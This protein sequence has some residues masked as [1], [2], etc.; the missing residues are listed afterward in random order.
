MRPATWSLEDSKFNMKPTLIMNVKIFASVVSLVIISNALSAQTTITMAGNVIVADDPVSPNL[1]GILTANR[2]LKIGTGTGIATIT[3]TTLSIYGGTI[4][5]DGGVS[6]G[7][8]SYARE[9][10][11]AFGQ[12]SRAGATGSIV[13]GDGANASATGNVAIGINSLVAGRYSIAFG[14]GATASTEPTVAIGLL[15]SA[16]GAHSIAIGSVSVSSALTAVALGYNTNASGPGSLALASSATATGIYSCAIGRVASVTGDYSIAIGSS[17]SASGVYSCAFGYGVSS[18][19]YK[20]SAIGSYPDNSI[21]TS[22]TTWVGTDPILLVGNGQTAA[23]ASNAFIVYKNGNAKVKGE[24]ETKAVI[25][26]EPSGGIPMGEFGR[27][28]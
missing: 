26:S 8:G 17:S 5:G 15:A 23:T 2:Y 13:L 12:N 9:L 6:I 19:G 1:E 27:Q 20:Q 25:V 3:P 22:S 21:V 28:E 24:I 16:T 4:I 7:Q 14:Y 11:F 18:I 10:S